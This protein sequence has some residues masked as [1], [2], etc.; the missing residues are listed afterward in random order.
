MATLKIKDNGVWKS[1]PAIKGDSIE[2]AGDFS[3][4]AVYKYRD[5][6]SFDGASYARKDLLPSSGVPVSDT[7][8]WQQIASIGGQDLVDAAVAARDA[9]QGYKD[10][11]AAFAAQLAAGTASPAGTYAN[12]AALI[13]ANPDHSKIYITLDDGKWCY[14]NGAAWVAGGQYQAAS[15][16]GDIASLNTRLGGLSFSVDPTD[17][18][19]NIT[20]TY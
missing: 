11:A 4:D 15:V 13:A 20:Y 14:H 7:T 6:V 10:A 19:L 1:I 9:A 3:I 2:L 18:G 17:A 8:H 12:L 16:V 5:V